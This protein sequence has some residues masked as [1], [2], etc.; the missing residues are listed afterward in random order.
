[1]MLIVLM[2]GCTI[3]K[4]G[5]AVDAGAQVNDAAFDGS[6]EGCTDPLMFRA[7][8]YCIDRRPATAAVSFEDASAA[9]MARGGY[10]CSEIEREDAC[11]VAPSEF[12]EGPSSTWEWSEHVCA[13]RRS[14]CCNVAAGFGECSS[15]EPV[16]GYHCCRGE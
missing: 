16:A 6:S 11:P 5:T 7:N 3:L 14:P 4:S 13:R 10:L 9:C 15:V 8:S 1:M 12:C 2:L